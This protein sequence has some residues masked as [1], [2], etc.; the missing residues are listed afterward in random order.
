MGQDQ[1]VDTSYVGNGHQGEMNTHTH[2]CAPEAPLP[3][4]LF[5]SSLTCPW[6]IGCTPLEQIDLTSHIELSKPDLDLSSRPSSSL[7]PLPSIL[8][9]PPSSP[10]IQ[11]QPSGIQSDLDMS[12]PN[13]VAPLSPG[14]SQSSLSTHLSVCSGPLPSPLAP[15]IANT[16]PPSPISDPL[17]YPL[18]A[19]NTQRHFHEGPYPTEATSFID[20]PRS[21]DDNFSITGLETLSQSEVMEF[22]FPTLDIPAKSVV[23]PTDFESTLQTEFEQHEDIFIA[24]G[25]GHLIESSRQNQ[26]RPLF[27]SP[28]HSTS[29][30]YPSEASTLHSPGTHTSGTESELA[31]WSDVSPARKIHEPPGRERS[32]E[33]PGGQEAEMEIDCDSH[34]DMEAEDNLDDNLRVKILDNH[35][36][37][38]LE[39]PMLGSFVRLF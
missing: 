34:I 3:S 27:R 32:T 22:Y 20:S 17:P 6:F 12:Y 14:M 24:P 33:P 38:K 23:R 15:P 28:L 18:H 16:G 10:E 11:E 7:R 30:G 26:P 9:S 36:T 37:Q 13:C 29:T 35:N 4:P 19:A 21:E 5:S 2:S 31:H 39:L 25:T 8:E 1:Q